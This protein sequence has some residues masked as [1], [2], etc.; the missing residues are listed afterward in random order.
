MSTIKKVNVALF[1]LGRAGNFYLPNLSNN[2]RVNFLYAVE[3]DEE[4]RKAATATYGVT[5]LAEGLSVG[6]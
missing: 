2:I 1:G 3:P 5:T 6:K 4:R